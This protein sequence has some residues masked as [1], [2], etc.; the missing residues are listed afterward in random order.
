[1]AGAVAGG[2]FLSALLQVLF[3]RMASREFVDFFKG[4]RLSDE[5]LRRL[6]TTMRTINRLL[7]DDEEKQIINRDLQVWLDDLKDAVYEAD[8]FLDEIAYEGLRSEI[9][10]CPQTDNIAII[11]NMKVELEKILDRL[12]DLVEQKDVLGSGEKIG[13]K[14]ET[15]TT[16]LVD[17]SAVFGRNND[18][19]DIVTLL[20]SDNAYGRSLGVIPIVGMCGVGKTTLAQLV[21]NDS[22]VQEWFDLKTWVCVSE[23]FSAFKINKDILKELGSKNCDT[24]TQNQ[25]HLE[26]KKELEGKKYLLVLDDVRD[27]K[28]D[29]WDILLKPLK[30][31]A[32][33]SKIIVTTQRKRVASVFTSAPPYHLKE[34]TD[35]DCWYLFEKHAFDYGDSS[36]HPELEGIGR[37]IV[38]KCKGLPLAVKSF[39]GLLRSER[40]LQEWE[41]ILRSNL[42]DLQNNNILPALRLSYHYLPKHLKRCFSYCSIFPK[43]CEFKQEEMVHL[44]MAEGFLIHL[45]SNQ[46][47]KEVGD[48]YFSDLVSRSFFQ[49]S[50]SHP[51][52]FVMHDLINDF[53]K[54]VAGEFCNTL[55]DAKGLKLAKKTRH[56][57][58]VRAKHGNLKEFEGTYERKVLRTFLLME[59]SWELDQN[60]NGAIH[61]LLPTLTRLRVLSL[62]QYSYL[63]D[64]IGNLKHLRYLNLFKASLKN[65][66]AIIHALY[67]LQTL[68]L[69]E[70]KDLVELP[71]SIGKLK[72]L[73]H[74]DLSATSIRKLPNCVIGL[75]NLETLIL[76]QCKDLTVLPTNMASLMNLHHLDTRE[77]NL[78]EM[79]LQMVN[80]KNLL[81]IQ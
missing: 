38:R 6:K 75:C 5:L 73:Q 33:G 52:C 44:W 14:H 68:I 57:S 51:S 27:A 47:M 25:L 11:M 28:Y 49:Q 58:Y 54:L 60:E 67:N 22:R 46:K 69:R 34:L 70:C 65:L 42:W 59:Q 31:G 56:L 35:D 32:Q 43:G 39:A 21:Y 63:P 10:T 40:E 7:D 30:F 24:K 16:S 48:E 66:H 23:E 4:Q 74:L 41:K 18:K 2:S 20:L 17:E 19:D 80:L 53:A 29:D 1:M 71:N 8:D 76:R 77:T 9:E 62:S 37:K 15:A 78:K 45:K 36:A 64:S 81:D 50:S 55:D 79:P 61:D 3:D 13:E 26:L 72:H 12:E